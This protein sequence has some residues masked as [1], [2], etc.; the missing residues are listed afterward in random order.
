[1]TSAGGRA[2]SGVMVSLLLAGSPTSAAAAP[3]ENSAEWLADADAAWGRRAEGATGEIAAAEPVERAIAGYRRALA[4][5]PGSDEARWKLVRAIHYRGRFCASRPEDRRRYFEEAR[6]L[7]NEGLERL[8]RMAAKTQGA[9]RVAAL[10]QAPGAASLYLWAAVAWGEWALARGKLAAVMQGAAEKVRDLAQ[11]SVDLDPRVDD[12]GG[13][14][15]LGRLHDEC[16][17]IP[18]VTGWVS[19]RAALGYLRQALAV[20]PDNSVNRLF[21]AE[22][23]LRHDP[24]RRPEAIALLTACAAMSPHPDYL[25]EDRHFSGRASRRLQE[26]RGRTGAVGSTSSPA[27]EGP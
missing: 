25:V 4:A 18:L 21:L 15:V 19:H 13:Y 6:R 22:A 2:V 23:I 27:E 3:P 14:R 17:R 1:M 8:D 20:A 10:R 9:A 7:A 11:T 24:A 12:G 16:P 5:D 26:L